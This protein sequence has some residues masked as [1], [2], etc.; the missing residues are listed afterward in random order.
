LAASF[1]PGLGIVT[2]TRGPVVRSNLAGAMSVVQRAAARSYAGA[3]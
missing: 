3:L 1:M 2:G